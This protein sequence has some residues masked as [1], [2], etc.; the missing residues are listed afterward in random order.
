M[1]HTGDGA[2][3]KRRQR[4]WDANTSNWKPWES[5]YFINSTVLGRVITET[6]KAPKS[7]QTGKKQTTYVVAGG[8]II[9]QQG[10]S[11][12][13]VESVGWRFT[14][15]T[16]FSSR[17]SDIAERDGL[18]NNVRLLPRSGPQKRPKCNDRRR[19]PTLTNMDVG[20]CQDNGVFMSCAMEAHTSL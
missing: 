2:E 18:D 7:T 3:A 13:N 12:T 5:V 14:D 1:Y 17:G 9:A 8:T 11:A 16:G 19:S 4:V 10:L 20:D 15:S 6:T